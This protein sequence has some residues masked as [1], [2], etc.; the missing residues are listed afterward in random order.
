M[1]SSPSPCMQQYPEVSSSPTF[2]HPSTHLLQSAA[3]N[4]LPTV[5]ASETLDSD[6]SKPPPSYEEFLTHRVKQEK[7]GYTPECSQLESS[8][9]KD[10]ELMKSAKLLY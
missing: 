7:T 4:N 1:T 2:M 9:K 5:I 6:P 8:E 3:V 10:G